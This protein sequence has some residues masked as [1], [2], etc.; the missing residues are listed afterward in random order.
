MLG[1]KKNN[2]ASWRYIFFPLSYSHALPNTTK[3]KSK[4]TRESFVVHKWPFSKRFKLTLKEP[5]SANERTHS[6]CSFWEDIYIKYSWY[7]LVY[8]SLVWWCNYVR[9]TRHQN[10]VVLHFLPRDNS[11]LAVERR[12][13]IPCQIALWPVS[14]LF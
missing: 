3:P 9:L 10:S 4:N 2:P 14:H 1:G 11:L 7:S 12:K 5:F 6:H 13:M 8:T